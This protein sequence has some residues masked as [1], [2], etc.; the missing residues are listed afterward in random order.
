MAEQEAR[1]A[2][3]P[4]YTANPFGERAGLGLAVSYSTIEELGGRIRI[5]SSPG[6]GTVATISLPLA[7]A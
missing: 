5:D 3:E 7:E 4:F 1:R 2:F 6:R